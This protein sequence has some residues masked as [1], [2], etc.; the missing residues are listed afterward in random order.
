MV[1]L[2]RGR[3]NLP[4]YRAGTRHALPDQS[5]GPQLPSQKQSLFQR[6]TWLGS[7]LPNLMMPAAAK[8][9]HAAKAAR[10][11]KRVGRAMDVVRVPAVL[12][13]RDAGREGPWNGGLNQ[14]LIGHLPVGVTVTGSGMMMTPTSSDCYATRNGWPQLQPCFRTVYKHTCFPRAVSKSLMALPAALAEWPRRCPWQL[15]PGPLGCCRLFAAVALHRQ[16]NSAWVFM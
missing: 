10:A 8:A 5:L 11:A 16:I 6:L 14:P 7:P 3:R 13:S 1:T 4:L 9:A 12:G 15:K 2:G